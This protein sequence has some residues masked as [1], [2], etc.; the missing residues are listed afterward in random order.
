MTV[1]ILNFT[2]A[3]RLTDT[4]KR[5]IQDKMYK[6]AYNIVYVERVKNWIMVPK[7]KQQ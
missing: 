7:P 5:I 2:E 1:E 3:L 4:G 6:N